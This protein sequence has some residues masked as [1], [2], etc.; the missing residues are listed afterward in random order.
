MKE[1]ELYGSP[2]SCS[3]PLPDVN[4][5]EMYSI[6]V[7]TIWTVVQIIWILLSIQRVELNEW[8]HKELRSLEKNYKRRTQ[9]NTFLF[10]SQT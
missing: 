5:G 8:A 2:P 1:N 4:L 9:F 10:F 7:E 6:Q 3:R